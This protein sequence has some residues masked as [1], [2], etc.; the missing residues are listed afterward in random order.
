MSLKTAVLQSSLW[1]WA[2][3]VVFSKPSLVSASEPK[4]ST[5]TDN[6]ATIS[7]NYSP[8]TAPKK[9]AQITSEDWLDESDNAMNQLTNVSELRDVSPGEWAYEALQSLIERYGCIVGYR[10]LTYRG[11]RALS[12]WEFAAGLNACINT[13]ERLLQENASVL[14]EDIDTLKRLAEEFQTELAALSGRVD[15]LEGRVTF[16]E[17]RQFTGGDSF[18]PVTKFGGEVIF[19][20]SAATGGDP[21]GTG[22]AQATFNHLTRLQIVSTFSGKD[23]LRLELESGNFEGF[24]FGDPDIF[25]TRTALLSFQSDTGNDIRLSMLEY[26]FAAFD[27]RVVFTFRPVGFS[28][29]SVLSANSPFFDV[30]RGSIS[31]FGLENPIFKIGNLDAGVGLDWLISDRVRLQVAYGANNSDNPNG[32]FIFGESAH[33]TAVQLLL[34]PS[35]NLLTGVSYVYGFLPDGNLNTFTGS[36]IADTSGFINQ[37]AHFHAVGGTLQWQIVPQLTFFTWGG[38]VATDGNLTDAFT[39]S[40]NYMFGLGISDLLQEGSLLGLMF[41]E[42]PKIRE[43]DGRGLTTGLIDEATSFHLEAFYR[44]NINDN[45]SITPGF[46]VVTNPG[47]IE[48]NN[49]IWVGTLRTTFRF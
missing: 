20:L 41:G 28:L 34:L 25:N 43:I 44:F 7:L 45:I 19:A 10:D 31:R 36:A 39:L 24:G 23:R 18:F 15:N 13:I 32:G 29:S 42:P 11:D 5:F 8:L 40:T 48:D 37:P 6:F 35:D 38:L 22:D 26:R 16:L 4:P 47:N 21:P 14:K 3:L 1:L 2:T 27:D 9:I 33:A 49:A 46:F 30:G 17:D 12:R